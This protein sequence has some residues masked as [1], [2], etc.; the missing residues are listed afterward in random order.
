MANGN[1]T[2]S[3]R[4]DDYMRGLLTFLVGLIIGFLTSV[5][6]FSSRVSALETVSATHTKELDGLGAK[7][8]AANAQLAAIVAR[9]K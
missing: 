5:A 6:A 7:M 3:R 1:P 4:M 2:L 8:D 9:L